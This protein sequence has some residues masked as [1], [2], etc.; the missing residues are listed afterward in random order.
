MSNACLFK[1][2]ISD[3][4]MHGSGPMLLLGDFNAS[5]DDIPDVKQ[6]IV[7]GRLHDLCAFPHLT[8]CEEPPHTCRSHNAS[9]SCRRDF[10]LA[11]SV[12]LPNIIAARVA[13]G[14]G[15]DVH[16]PI[17]VS[18]SR[19]IETMHRVLASPIVFEKPQALTVAEWRRE[20]EDVATRLNDQ[21]Q[22]MRDA[23]RVRDAD[24]F[25]EMWTKWMHDT[26]SEVHAKHE[27]QEVARRQV[28]GHVVI[29]QV[30]DAETWSK[31]QQ[32]SIGGQMCP[33]SRQASLL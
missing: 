22:S 2:I 6:S 1:A 28:H 18:M 32:K 23:L 5:L 15:Y 3:M 19:R 20:I 12:L 26:F 14:E 30:S 21:Q 11:T 16:S 17:Y 8:L 33:C 10:V 9:S 25:W 24:A 27:Q 31:K 29:R 7:E 4:Q 13:E